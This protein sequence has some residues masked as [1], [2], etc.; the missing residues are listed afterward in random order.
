MIE[1]DAYLDTGELRRY[2]KINAAY[3]LGGEDEIKMHVEDLLG[4]KLNYIVEVDYNAFRSVIDALGGVEMKITQ[5]MYYDDDEQD[6]HINFK[7]GETVLLDGK[8]AEEFFRWRKNND[9]TGGEEGDLGRINN[10]QQ[11]ISKVIDKAL[12]PS[13]IFKAPKILESISEN[14]D[15]NIPANKII[16]L[17]MKMLR[18]KSEDIIMTTLKGEP[19]T[20]YGESFLIANEELNRDLIN[21]LNTEN[22]S[23]ADSITSTK[24]EAVRIL[25]LNGTKINGLASNARDNLESLGYVNVE[26][27]NTTPVSKS[28]IQTE[29]KELKQL[30]KSDMDIEKFEKISNPEYKE[31]DAVILLGEDYN[32][33]N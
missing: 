32:R 3:V 16:S 33:F 28:I 14:V 22:S 30:L 26:V 1:V 12:R 17:G 18:L 13:I 5:D 27:G 24:R 19:T 31:Y 4:I 15:T 25:V 2:W 20:I 29:N 9:G 8:K 23:E 10:Q 7:A 6:L 11:F 21:A